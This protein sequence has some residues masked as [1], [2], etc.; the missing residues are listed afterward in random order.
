MALYVLGECSTRES[1]I[2]R[3]HVQGCGRCRDIIQ[4]QNKMRE[5][6][7]NI[8]FIQTPQDLTER[9]KAL[10]SEKYGPNL[11]H[12][13]AAFSRHVFN[14]LN[15][16]GEIIFG[17]LSQPSALLRDNQV[18]KRSNLVIKETFDNLLI[19]VEISR[20]E[21]DQNSVV[22]HAADP[23]KKKDVKN[24]RFTLLE[25]EEELESRSSSDGKTKFEEI[26]PGLYTVEIHRQDK[27]IGAIRFQLI[28]DKPQ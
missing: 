11:L 6:P 3:Q 26:K 7:N 17:P 27:L 18:D 5:E 4:M 13:K 15:T 21:A 8:D 19:K 2:I 23:L 24:F 1:E 10:V 12:V 22:I 14:L 20:G 28:H 16:T 9:A 25:N